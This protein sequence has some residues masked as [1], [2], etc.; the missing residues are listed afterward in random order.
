[1]ASIEAQKI[2]ILLIKCSNL[3]NTKIENIKIN[4]LEQVR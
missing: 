3:I 4:Y 1:M 2:N